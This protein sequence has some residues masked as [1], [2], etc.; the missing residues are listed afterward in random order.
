M[1]QS[2]HGGKRTGAGRPV[3]VGAT[4]RKTVTLDQETLDTLLSISK[5]LSQA[6]RTI[7]R[8]QKSDTKGQ[9][10]EYHTCTHQSDQRMD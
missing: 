10:D 2:S 9:N 3:S 6:I 7:A 5:N 4:I 1:S 8:N